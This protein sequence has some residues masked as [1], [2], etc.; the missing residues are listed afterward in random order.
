M[1]KGIMLDLDNTLYDYETCNEY[2][3]Y[4]LFRKIEGD[5]GVAGAEK[6]FDE[7]RKSVKKSL[8]KT[9]A[10][11]SRLLYIGKALEALGIS[12]LH[13]VRYHDFFWEKYFEKMELFESVADF[14]EHAKNSGMKICI[15]TD[16]TAEIQMKKI[17]HLG[18]EGY[19]DF[20]VSSEEVGEDKPS[21]KVFCMALEKMGMKKE[22][23]VMVGDD[24]E[25]DIKGAENAGIR[26]VKADPSIFASGRLVEILQAADRFK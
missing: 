20:I 22:D 4:E 11:H 18:I 14:L 26:A 25:K 9:A 24:E 15:V 23:V 17:I 19:V 16:L 8:E 5:M 1:I 7:A 13:S 3:K 21:S 12:A 6:A 10:G 2:A